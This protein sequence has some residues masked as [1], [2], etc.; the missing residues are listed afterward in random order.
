MD[1]R[2]SA[3]NHRSGPPLERVVT[4]SDMIGLAVRFWRYVGT[5]AVLGCT[6]A[7]G[8]ALLTHH[9]YRAEVTAVLAE[10]T[11]SNPLSRLAGQ[12]G[13]VA[14]LAGLT[15]MELSVGS[16]R[17]E[18]LAL[19]RSREFAT[20]V[21]EERRLMP[22]LFADRWDS[23]RGQWRVSKPEDV[24]T[25]SDAWYLFDKR[26]RTVIED[27]DRGLV[28]LRIELRD[29]RLAADLANSMVAELNEVLRQRKLEELDASLAFLQR[30]YETATLVQLRDVI[31][32]VMEAQVSERTLANSRKD[33]A[34]RVV[35]PATVPDARRYVW[36]KPILFVALG[37][38]VGS[39]AGFTCAVLVSYRRGA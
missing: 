13:G 9:I 33:Y 1:A 24:P 20:K 27:R 37:L 35:D 16:N 26:I 28:T 30:A 32:T 7:A 18:T 6:I 17:N 22:V 15:G 10:T 31:S 25:Q 21:I 38:V 12:L 2:T 3:D 4:L 23:A 8:V 36:P 5:G 39:M 11:G 29:R 19:L 14:G 34:L